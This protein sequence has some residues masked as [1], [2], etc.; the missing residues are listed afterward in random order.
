MPNYTF[1]PDSC[2]DLAK[3]DVTFTS[4]ALIITLIS[5]GQKVFQKSYGKALALMCSKDDLC[6]G[7]LVDNGVFS[8]KVDFNKPKAKIGLEKKPN[9]N[10]VWGSE[11]H[12]DPGVAHIYDLNQCPI[13]LSSSKDVVTIECPCETPG[14]PCTNKCYQYGGK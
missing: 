5:T 12:D 6:V 8:A 7:K 14:K 3:H 2:Y 9:A 13:R 11:N 10:R 4:T 1:T